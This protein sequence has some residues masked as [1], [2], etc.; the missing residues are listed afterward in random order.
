[1]KKYIHK[2]IV[3]QLALSVT[4]FQNCSNEEPALSE[5]EVFINKISKTWNTGKVMLDGED[6]TRFFADMK[7]TF[8]K[9]KSI[10]VTNPVPPIWS[11]S[12]TFDLV[13]VGNSFRL[14]RNDGLEITVNTL[15]EQKL[16]MNFMFSSEISGGRLDDVKGNFSFEMDQ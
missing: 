4:L 8:N 12:G 7:I 16:V 2:I 1:M 14:E 9:N 15:T 13:P 11:N 5:E 6:V 3:V 10:T